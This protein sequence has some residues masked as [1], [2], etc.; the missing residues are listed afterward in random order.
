MLLRIIV[1]IAVLAII[2]YGLRV[3]RRNVNDFINKDDED[4]LRRDREDRER[5]G[6]VDLK[7][8]DDGVFRPEDEKADSDRNK[9]A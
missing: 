1:L 8:D 5:G 2:I 9:G 7:Q 3:I 6:I 4:K